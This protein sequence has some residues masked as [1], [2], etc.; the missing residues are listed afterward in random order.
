MIDAD[1]FWKMNPN[2]SRP[3]NDLAGTRLGNSLSVVYVGGPP[4]PPLGRPP[5]DHVKNDDVELDDLTEDD[6]L[7][8]CPTVLGFSFGDKLWG[9]SFCSYVAIYIRLIYN[10]QRSSLLPISKTSNGR[11][12]LMLVCRYLM[13]KE[14]LLWLS[15]RLA[16]TLA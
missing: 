5:R 7:V 9:T 11:P 10:T 3:R 4:P 13:S 15:S 14:M 6:F 12:R 16:L 1:F 2:Y 8:C